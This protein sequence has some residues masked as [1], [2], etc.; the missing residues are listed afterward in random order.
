MRTHSF[1]CSFI[2]V[3]ILTAAALPARGED[4]FDKLPAMT[5]ATHGKQALEAD[6]YLPKGKG[7]F[8]AALVVHGGAWAHGNKRQVRGIGTTLAEHGYTAVAI[9]YRLAPKHKF[10]AQIDDCR[11]AVRWMRSRAKELRLDPQRIAAVGYSAGGHLVSLLG[12]NQDPDSADDKPSSGDNAS[13]LGSRVQAVVAGGAPCDFRLLPR[14]N[15]I[16]AYW[17]G[18]TRGE[19]EE[20]YRLASPLAFVSKDD[21]PMFFYHGEKD[22]LVP[23]FSLLVMTA[24]LKGAGVE[25]ELHVIPEA[26]HIEAFLDQPALDKACEFLDKRLK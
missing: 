16:L 23:Q 19:K 25:A 24:A 4:K 18:G 6:V 21:P 2:A 22:F 15:E 9:D 5:Y 20:A 13:R 10:P 26:G 8:P 17:L 12:T 14:D 7:P 11:A 1:D 3:C